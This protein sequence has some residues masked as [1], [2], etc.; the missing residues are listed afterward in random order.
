[1]S[2]LAAW[3]DG[4]RRVNRAPAMVMGRGVASRN[5]LRLSSTAPNP[6]IVGLNVVPIPDA[7]SLNSCIQS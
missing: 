7:W 6:M 1:M 5:P 3:L 4:V 2:A